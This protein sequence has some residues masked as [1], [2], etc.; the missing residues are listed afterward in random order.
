MEDPTFVPS[1]SL[2][3]TVRTRT[4]PGTGD[5]TFIMASTS[6][7]F[8]RVPP[9]VL[10]RITARTGEIRMD[11]SGWFAGCD[12]M[13]LYALKDAV[14]RALI[15]MGVRVT[16]CART[17]VEDRQWV[18]VRDG[19]PQAFS[20]DAVLMNKTAS[21][22][23]ALRRL[24]FVRR[25]S[26]CWCIGLW[27]TASGA[28][29]GVDAKKSLRFVG[30]GDWDVLADKTVRCFGKGGADLFV[31]DMKRRTL[32]PLLNSDT[33]TDDKFILL[34]DAIRYMCDLDLRAVYADPR[35]S[36][37]VSYWTLGQLLYSR[38]KSIPF[39][40]SS[41]VGTLKRLLQEAFDGTP[42]AVV[43]EM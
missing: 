26:C 18:V 27:A 25:Q 7:L 9:P 22:D 14:N 41:G 11:C 40:K 5:V 13:R 12:V 2:H 39:A 43:E 34:R 38:G 3:H 42:V 16:P 17:R 24:E 29:S 30:K 20:G 8:D 6:V 33:D 35:L 19:H 21:M 15:L 36:N 31:L 23:E 10:F 32:T 28:A 37:E 1:S 4:D